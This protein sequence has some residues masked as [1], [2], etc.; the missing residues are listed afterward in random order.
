MYPSLFMSISSPAFNDLAD[1]SCKSPMPWL[2]SSAIAVASE[3]MNPSKPQ[4]SRRISCISHVFM[5]AGMPSNSLKE[6]I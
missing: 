4:E 5:E 3:T 6:L 2:T 1:T